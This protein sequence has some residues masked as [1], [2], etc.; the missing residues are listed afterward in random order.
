MIKKRISNTK[1]KV[2]KKEES[3]KTS[4]KFGNID[5]KTY[6]EE[7]IEVLEILEEKGIDLYDPNRYGGMYLKNHKNPNANVAQIFGKRK[8]KNSSKLNNI[9]KEESN[10]ELT[11][12]FEYFKKSKK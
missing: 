4:P 8:Q 3:E 12:L 2:T 6:A 1:P 9:N 11:N 7:V 5:V 10:N